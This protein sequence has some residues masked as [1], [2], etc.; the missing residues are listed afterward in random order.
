[1]YNSKSVRRSKNSWLHDRDR[2]RCY[3]TL[4]L[5]ESCAVSHLRT[6]IGYHS[7]LSVAF[8]VMNPFIWNGDSSW[9][10]FVSQWPHN[11]TI[12]YI[13]GGQL[14][15]PQIIIYFIVMDLNQRTEI[16]I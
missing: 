15:D 13:S 3:R 8:G 9:G 7:G 5:S 6:S 2:R 16:S 4:R 11:S 10:K 1:M 14:V 12:L